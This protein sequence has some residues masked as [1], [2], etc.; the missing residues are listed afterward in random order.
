[1]NRIEPSKSFSGTRHASDE[2]DDVGPLLLSICNDFDEAICGC[3]QILG[4]R[5]RM[6]D[7]A[8]FVTRVEQLSCLYDRWDGLVCGGFPSAT[9]KLDLACQFILR[10]NFT[11]WGEQR[12]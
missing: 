4:T 7:L 11:H 3:A 10:S 12:S 5:G 9:I 8:N 2:S 1:M 6:S